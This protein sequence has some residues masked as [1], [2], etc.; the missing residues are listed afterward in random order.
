M[1]R[2]VRVAAPRYVRVRHL[3]RACAGALPR[4]RS[5][6]HQAA[7]LFLAGPASR[8]RVRARGVPAP[9]R[10]AVS[11]RRGGTRLLPR[12]LLH[13]RSLDDLR[14]G[15]EAPTGA[16]AHDPAREATAAA[17]LLASPLRLGAV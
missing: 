11:H 16:H 9:E 5:P 7:P 15:A 12:A 1:G 6:R 8:L 17:P 4:P 10:E 14:G 2:S 13:P 3:G